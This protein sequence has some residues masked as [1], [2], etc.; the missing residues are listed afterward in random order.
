MGLIEANQRRLAK[1]YV[2]GSIPED[3]LSQESQPLNQRREY[4][5]AEL[6]SFQPSIR[7][8]IDLG[9]FE[10]NLP[11]VAARLREWVLAANDGDLE[12]FPRKIK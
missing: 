11:N 1:L 3:I 2:D 6:R 5:E 9:H 8:A 12:L 4:L 7:Q 10:R